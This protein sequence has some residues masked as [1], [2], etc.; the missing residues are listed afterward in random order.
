MRRRTAALISVAWLCTA[1]CSDPGPGSPQ[2]EYPTTLNPLD[3]EALNRLRAAYV[4]QNPRL[5]ST[6]DSYGFTSGLC[7]EDAVGL[8]PSAD[9]GAMIARA[10]A[11]IAENARFTGVSDSSSLHVK[12]YIISPQRLFLRIRF[13][14][15]SYAGL[16]V[17]GSGISIHMDSCGALAIDGHHSREIY[18]PDPPSLSADQAQATILGLEI[19]WFD[20]SG[21]PQVYTVTEGSFE[22]ES[23]R[24]ILPCERETSIQLRVAWRIP[25]GP[26]LPGWYV[27]VDTMDG[28]ILMV[29]Q[30]FYT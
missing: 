7:Y 14:P 21:D 18:V 12:S 24:V 2:L 15:Q 10:K 27:Y 9:I 20:S 26:S 19:T 29:E 8:A 25:V 16:E 3:D 30:R 17:V 22:G 13:D 28:Q 6:L 11:A 23:V 1:S 5:C 4:T